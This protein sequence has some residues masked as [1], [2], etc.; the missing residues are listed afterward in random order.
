MGP[1]AP[2]HPAAS[3]L[4]VPDLRTPGRPMATL[5]VK[6]PDATAQALQSQATQL[7]TSRGALARA[8]LV[9]AMADLEAR[10]AQKVEG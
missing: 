7:G 3:P 10:T 4:I 9:C 6:V 2:R 8:L 5:P 1:D